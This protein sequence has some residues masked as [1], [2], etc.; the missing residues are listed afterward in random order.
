LLK[1]GQRR[2]ARDGLAARR[3]SPNFTQFFYQAV[4]PRAW[5]RVRRV[6]ACK[7]EIVG[8][9]SFTI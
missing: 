8:L 1:A 9:N 7:I 3:P 4:N 2:T 5:T 6:W